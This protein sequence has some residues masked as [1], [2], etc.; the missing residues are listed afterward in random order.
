[1]QTV[2]ITGGTG[3]IGKA[4]STQLADKGYKVII[5]TRKLP[6]QRNNTGNI[7]YALW[8]VQEQSIDIAPIQQAD[9]IVHLTGA[10]VLDK[11]WTTVY[12]K[13][14]QSSRVQS[15]RLI[16]KALKENDNKVKAVIS[17]SAIGWYGRDS[18]DVLKKGGFTET[19]P[20]DNNF[21]G[22]TCRLWEESITPVETLGKR[23]VIFRTGIVL[24][25]NGG[26]FAEFKKPLRFGIAAILGSG[27]Q[28]ISWIHI[29]DLCRMY[30]DAI[31]NENVN[32]AYNAAAPAPVDNKTLTLSLAK[33][34][35]HSF[36]IPLHVPSF[37]LKLIL[38]ESSIEV[39]KST[40]VSCDKIKSTGFT[41]LYPAID[42]AI[43]ELCS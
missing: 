14:I 35:R 27:T 9:Y 33:K 24:S 5:L 34:L 21:L 32:G 7:R 3:L 19:N 43:E 13:E 38:G 41:F 28:I 1:M 15:S 12:K 42:A 18:D 30:I 26:A 2:L 11:R 17:A 16:V 37:M 20:A 36:F 23:L 39:L 40:Y 6:V 8:N 25:N 22:E 10:G 29:D 31:E 4:L